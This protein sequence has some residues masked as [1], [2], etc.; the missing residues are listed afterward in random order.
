MNIQQNLERVNA[1]A[2]DQELKSMQPEQD[3]KYVLLECTLQMMDSV[4][5]VLL[6]NLPHTLEQPFAILA[7]VELK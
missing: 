1:T 2:A 5:C 6:W 4:K 7:I 3:A